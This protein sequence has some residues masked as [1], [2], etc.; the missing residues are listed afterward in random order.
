MATVVYD[1]DPT[2]QAALKVDDQGRLLVA[3]AGGGGGSSSS[4]LSAD[5]VNALIKKAIDEAPKTSVDLSS[6]FKKDGSET[7]TGN[8]N[9]GNFRIIGLGTPKFSGDV[10]SKG[11]VDTEVLKVKN[12]TVPVPSQTVP[13]PHIV[14]KA[15]Y[16]I[17][18]SAPSG[19]TG[20]SLK[21][22][23]TYSS[24]SSKP[25]TFDAQTT[26]TVTQAGWYRIDFNV[27]SEAAGKAWQGFFLNNTVSKFPA[28]TASETAD[29]AMGTNSCTFMAQFAAGTA[30]RICLNTP[31]AMEG[32]N[33]LLQV[34]YV[35][36]VA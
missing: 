21:A 9:M 3:M 23:S 30:Y 19:G 28:H 17:H 35:G 22:N 4:G 6:Y 25:I 20:A 15:L 36:P 2:L 10:V 34:S 11:Y 1:K 26:V 27:A 18:R 13:T 12:S 31:Q 7:M 16:D 8:L 14:G 33:A 24:N 29:Y 32:R 5:E